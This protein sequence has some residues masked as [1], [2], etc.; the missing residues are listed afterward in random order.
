MSTSVSC[1]LRI[2]LYLYQLRQSV[3]C[4][5]DRSNI[6]GNL[7]RVSRL[8]S[9]PIS[10]QHYCERNGIPVFLQ[11]RWLWQL[12]WHTGSW[13][14]FAGRTWEHWASS[15]GNHPWWSDQGGNGARRFCR[16]PDPVYIG[17]R[18]WS[19]GTRRMK[20]WS[21]GWRGGRVWGHL[22]KRWTS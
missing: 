22:G 21:L 15:W 16:P 12:T 13:H 6:H 1:F 9:C 20:H 3:F 17:Y 11:G 19:G 10:S 2:I 14:R 8:Y 18:C 4:H 7:V 5:L